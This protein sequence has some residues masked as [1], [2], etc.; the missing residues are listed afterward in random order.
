MK[1]LLLLGVAA[2][3][4][5]GAAGV[6][7][8]ANGG[9]TKSRYAYD[10]YNADNWLVDDG[11]GGRVMPQTYPQEGDIVIFD[12]TID[13]MSLFPDDSVAPALHKAVFNAGNTIHQ[14]YMN[15]KAGGEGLWMK[16][17]VSMSWWAGLRF[18]GTG[19]VPIHV[20]A[21]C[22]FNNQKGVM[23]DATLVK[24]GGG[25]FCTANEGAAVFGP[26]K[27]LLRGGT[28]VMRAS[29]SCAGLEFVFDAN[30]PALR[31]GMRNYAKNGVNNYADLV[32]N[33][34]AIYESASVDNT[35]HG[36]TSDGANGHL[37]A[38][39]LTGTPKVAEQRFTGQLYSTAGVSFLPGA[40]QAGGADYVFTFAKAVSTAG[41]GL[42]V[43]NGTM[44]LAEGASFTNLQRV[45]VGSTGTFKVES[46]SGANFRAAALG[47]ATGSKLDLGAGVSLLFTG[48][49]LDGAD[50][51]DGVYTATGAD[52]TTAAD[53]VVGDGAVRLE[54][55]PLLDPVVLTV[56]S[57]TATLADALAA[58]NAAHAGEEGFADVTFESL[59]G[60]ADKARTLVKRGA[61]RLNLT[62][63]MTGFE[64]PIR[65]EE[66]V[67]YSDVKGALGKT[68]NDA[69]PIGV[70]EGARYQCHAEADGHNANRIFRIRG[71]GP[72][73][74]GAIWCSQKNS[75]GRTG[76]SG[77]MI[78]LDA[79]ATIGSDVWISFPE[80][81]LNGHV[82][83]LTGNSAES[84]AMV[85]IIHG[86]GGVVVSNAAWRQSGTFADATRD[87][88]FRVVKNGAFRFWDNVLGG[89]SLNRWTFDFAADCSDL[90]GDVGFGNASGTRD[91]GDN[92]FSRPVSL[93]KQV[94]LH[95]Q[96]D[97]YY[98]RMRFTGPVSGAGGFQDTSSYSGKRYSFWLHLENPGNS[99]TGGIAFNR[100]T[101]WSYA[102]GAIPAD[103]GP[104]VLNRADATDTS[105]TCYDGV[106]FPV[107]DVVH[108]LPDLEVKGAHAA[109][110]QCGAGAWKSVVKRDAGTLEY[111]SEIGAPKAEILGGTFKLPRGA[112]PGL[113]EGVKTYASAAAAQA[114]LAGT[115]LPKDH[116]A[117][118]P[119][120][121]NLRERDL[122]PAWQQNSLVVY[123]GY[124][125]NRTGETKTWTLAS[126]L[127]DA[128]EVR[129]DGQVVLSGG[130][131]Q[132]V[133]AN[134][135]LTPGPH[136]FEWRACNGADGTVGPYSTSA[137]PKNFGFA[138]DRQ[139]R[140][141]VANTN[142]FV[143]ATDAGD[144][145]LFTRT[146]ETTARLPVFDEMKLAGNATLDLNGNAYAAAKIG[147]S[148]AV[149]SSATDAMGASAALS[150]TGALK[151][152]G[153]ELT[154]DTCLAS[155]VPV[156]F[157]AGAAVELA[158]PDK[159][160]RR[161]VKS[162][163]VLRAPSITV[164]G[165]RLPV[166]CEDRNWVLSVGGAEGAQ[167]LALQ[168]CAG[169]VLI[170]R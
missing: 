22:S 28:I 79:D 99:F 168:Y 73:G 143:L 64:G 70:Y 133:S 2:P 77:K 106:A 89:A 69:S 58:Y 102:D 119:H 148:G 138:V 57:G 104:V 55:V 116:V 117:R 130:A 83:T 25:S 169:T 1:K 162:F 71:A 6:T 93:A 149:T 3:L 65:I 15:F 32:I 152:Y 35:A 153:A 157:A 59:N 125:W 74:K 46:G 165:D 31:L 84:T 155:Q 141:D 120:M 142:N 129:V 90:Y 9:G 94:F 54:R 111:Y 170:F 101:I 38:V 42:A 39:R 75:Y 103:G 121:A 135:T 118:G 144:G 100:G 10:W 112:A 12:K 45:D 14:G 8:Y 44:R 40:K 72:D 43:T 41:G 5:C 105:R 167:T 136:A 33:N 156:T 147:G 13:N 56:A 134:V 126:A 137:W 34:G 82:L 127:R 87:N 80:I 123:H 78:H 11:A 150:I 113:W 86:D 92:T 63:A 108:H 49:K 21:G 26:D 122:F 60:G 131:D 124:V 159:V 146:T 68:P 18:T 98:G 4:F 115:E 27:V 66:G 50:L 16:D 95:A 36:I 52:G 17:G 53:W 140:G 91:R 96:T 163:T 164:A 76:Q 114:A 47:L 19:E 97:R 29:G 67:L 7:Y 62:A 51:P 109:R 37:Y 145:L 48:A 85:G 128:V 107:A 20:G 24:T 61:G 154:A 110:V 151:V 160:V 81:T 23:G 88:V 161:G 158:D 166:A 30:D 139:G 132:V